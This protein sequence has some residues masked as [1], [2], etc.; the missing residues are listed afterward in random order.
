MEE[1]RERLR[2]VRCL[3][4][5]ART[6]PANAT[7]SNESPDT[8]GRSSTSPMTAPKSTR[9]DTGRSPAGEGAGQ[10]ILLPRGRV[11]ARSRSGGLLNWRLDFRLDGKELSQPLP[12]EADARALLHALTEGMTTGAPI[13]IDDEYII[14]PRLVA[15]VRLIEPT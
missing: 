8:W 5:H 14:N 2:L 12:S 4:R 15:Y 11:R 3:P 7:G 13:P 9:I 1:H 10:M 6:V